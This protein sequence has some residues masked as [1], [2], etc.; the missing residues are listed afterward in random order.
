MGIDDDVER[1]TAPVAG[2]DD[3]LARVKS[4]QADVGADFLA[5]VIAPINRD[6]QVKLVLVMAVV[7]RQ[8]IADRGQ[9][10]NGIEDFSATRVFSRHDTT[11]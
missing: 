7:D 2:I 11:L 6:F 10:F 5:V 8:Q 1:V 9:G 4:Q 3:G